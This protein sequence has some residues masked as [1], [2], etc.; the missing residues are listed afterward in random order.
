MSSGTIARLTGRVYLTILLNMDSL[1][2]TFAALADPTRRAILARLATGA[3]TVG[4]LAEPFDISL[5][6]VSRH[7]KVLS[8]AGLIERQAEAQFRRCALRGEGLRG[9][10]D[11]IESYR[12]FWA[13]EFDRLAAYLEDSAPD[14]PASRPSREPKGKAR[15]RK[16]RR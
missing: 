1:S 14:E 10:S 16:P 5:P 2:Q 13:D 15:V 12:R 7:L 11:W 3:A 9:A 6:A 4:E 8:E